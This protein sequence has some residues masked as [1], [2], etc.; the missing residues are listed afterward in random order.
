MMKNYFRKQAHFSTLIMRYL[1]PT[2][3]V[4]LYS[5][6]VFFVMNAQYFQILDLSQVQDSA[7]HVPVFRTSCWGVLCVRV[8]IYIYIYIYITSPDRQE[9]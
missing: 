7:L 9:T 5:S 8:Y 4:P 6:Y 2:N 3:L 1:Y